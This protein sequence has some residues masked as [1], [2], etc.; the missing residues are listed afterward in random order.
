MG[1]VYEISALSIKHMKSETFSLNGNKCEKV[2]I[3]SVRYFQ[4]I[5]MKSGI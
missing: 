5:Q 2:I 1:L 4:K 3:S